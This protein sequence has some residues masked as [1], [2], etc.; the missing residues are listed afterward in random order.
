MNPH[1]ENSPAEVMK[2]Q[3]GAAPWLLRQI[4]IGAGGEYCPGDNA[5]DR[6]SSG[7][8]AGL[9]GSH[10][11]KAKAKTVPIFKPANVKPKVTVKRIIPTSLPDHPLG[12]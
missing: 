11:W 6:S 2:A 3:M 9:S 12:Y 4:E 1:G 10:F 5:P 7:D 8:R